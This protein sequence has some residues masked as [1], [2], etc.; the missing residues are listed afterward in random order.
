MEEKKDIIGDVAGS[1]GDVA[2]SIGDVA[3]DIGNIGADAL[4]GLTEYP[5][6]FLGIKP[7]YQGF[8][9]KWD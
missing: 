3:G 1:I 8:F 2:G 9:D 4:E 5:S 7:E 6:T